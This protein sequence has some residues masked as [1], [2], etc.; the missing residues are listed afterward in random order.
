[1]G[2]FEGLPIGWALFLCIIFQLFPSYP[3]FRVTSF[4]QHLIAVHARFYLFLPLIPH[5]YDS[6]GP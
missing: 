2:N 3:L 5:T 1:I 4:I 6:S